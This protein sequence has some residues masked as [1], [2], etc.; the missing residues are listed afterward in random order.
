MNGVDEAGL[1]GLFGLAS[2]VT[3]VHLEGV[4]GRFGPVAPDAVED[5]LTGQDATGVSEQELQQEELRWRQPDETVAA[6]SFAR[7]DVEAQ[8]GESEDLARARRSPEEG[9]HSGKELVEGERLGE[10]VVGAGVEAG[11]PV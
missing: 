9:A 3:H 8:I 10:V 6:M 1:V 5:E 2:Q 4:R 11:D 7:V